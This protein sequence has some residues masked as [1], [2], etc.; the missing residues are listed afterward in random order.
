MRPL[1]AF[2]LCESPVYGCIKVAGMS[3]HDDAYLSV[4]IRFMY[5]TFILVSQ[6]HNWSPEHHFLFNFLMSPSDMYV[7]QNVLSPWL[8]VWSWWRHQMETFSASLALC[9]GNSP[10]TGEFPSQKQVTRSFDVFFDPHLNKRLYKQSRR[11]WFE[12]PPWPLWRQC[13]VFKS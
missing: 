12:T 7:A 6:S 8:S 1:F 4:L 5:T 11:R 3:T 10:V 13:T 9:E 2:H